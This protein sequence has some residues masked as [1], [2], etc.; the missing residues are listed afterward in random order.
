MPLETISNSGP[1]S[2]V[3]LLVVV[4]CAPLLA[5]LLLSMLLKASRQELSKQVAMVDRIEQLSQMGQ[6]HF[7]LARET[8]IWS[9]QMCRIYGLDK[10]SIHAEEQQEDRH[11]DSGD[12]LWRTLN[13]HAEV[14]ESFRIEYDIIR[15]DGEERLLRMDALNNFDTHGIL[16]TI[17]AVVSDVTDEY[18]RAAQLVLERSAALKQVAEAQALALTDPLTGLANRRRVMAELDRRILQCRQEERYLSLIIFDL[19]NFKSINDTYGHQIGDTMLKRLG[20]IALAQVR[21]CDTVGRVGGD[22]FVWLMPNACIEIASNAAERLCRVIAESSGI[23]EVPAVTASVG[24]AKWIAGDT[25]LSLLARADE[26]LYSAKD[27]G[28]NRVR[29]AA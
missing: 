18:Q 23:A 28:R 5:A 14:R 13:D 10:S 16:R 1:D 19:D 24:Y 20:A 25:G 29:M 15:A 7:D 12:F 27:A 22:E 17:D 6:W 4:V 9:G 26:A 8:E 3:I 21:D 11:G 2:G